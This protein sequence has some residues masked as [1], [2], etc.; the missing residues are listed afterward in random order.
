MTTNTAPQIAEVADPRTEEWLKGHGASFT[1]TSIPL[2]AINKSKSHKNQSRFT[3]LDKG[4]VETY[5]AAMERGDRFPAIVVWKDGSEFVVA[6]GNH[7]VESKHGVGGTNIGA[8][9]LDGASERQV[10]TLTFE[11]NAKHGLPASVEER[12][13]H[14]VYLVELGVE[15]K[16]A[17]AMVN[18]PVHNLNKAIHQGRADARLARLGVDRWDSMP[19]SVRGRINHVRSDVTLKELAQLIVEATLG[20]DT[21]DDLV[22][23]INKLGSE[24]EQIA[25]VRK[26][27][28]TYASKISVTSGGRVPV[29]TDLNRLLRSVSYVSNINQGNL[30]TALTTLSPT[31]R[32]ELGSK[33]SKTIVSLMAAKQK[34]GA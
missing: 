34:L 5:K 21:V 4:V 14:G 32:A 2:S 3:A 15:Q 13:A 22:V 7:R 11:A 1:L 20:G 24:A 16:Q 18:V 8:Y 10:Q 6:D 23:A 29:P 31:E 30:E 19:P 27:R 17:A 33:I 28:K 25:E 9:V 12:L 26:V